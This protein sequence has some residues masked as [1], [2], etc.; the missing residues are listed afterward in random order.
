MAF[1]L[2]NVKPV[3]REVILSHLSCVQVDVRNTAVAFLFDED[4]VKE[5]LYWRNEVPDPNLQVLLLTTVSFL[6]SS[7]GLVFSPKSPNNGR[8]LLLGIL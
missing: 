8:S 4:G 7:H 3:R 2:T 1:S 5:A 6:R